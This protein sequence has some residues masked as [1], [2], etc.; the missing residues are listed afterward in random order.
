MGYVPSYPFPI[1]QEQLKFLIVHVDYFTKWVKV[2]GLVKI[3]HANI[4][5]FIKRNVL[6]RYGILQSIVIDNKTQ[7]MAKNMNK[8]WRFKDK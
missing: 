8:L 6:A 2:E 3:A 5:K 1:A 7:F 4:L